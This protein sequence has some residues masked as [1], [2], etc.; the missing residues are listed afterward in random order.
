MVTYGLAFRYF[1]LYRSLLSSWA[2]FSWL[3]ACCTRWYPP[4]MPTTRP[5]QSRQS[6]LCQTLPFGATHAFLGNLNI[7]Q[8][9]YA[10]LAASLQLACLTLYSLLPFPCFLLLKQ[11]S[12]TLVTYNTIFKKS[13]SSRGRRSKTGLTELTSKRWQAV[14]LLGGTGGEPTPL[15]FPVSRHHLHCLAPGPLQSHVGLSLFQAPISLV[16]FSS[17]SR[18]QFQGPFGLHWA[19]PDNRVISKLGDQQP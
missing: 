7:Y 4:G 18:F 5:P 10:I 11:I 13:F 16:F 17:T 9:P 1:V 15:P 3:S 2:A 8:C 14:L 12:A 19:H 6:L